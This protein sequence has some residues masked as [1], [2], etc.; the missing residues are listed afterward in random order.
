MIVAWQFYCQV[1][2]AMEPVPSG[3][4]MMS[5]IYSNCRRVSLPQRFAPWEGKPNSFS[6]PEKSPF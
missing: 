5:L 3:Y 6:A 4:G 1:R 2:E